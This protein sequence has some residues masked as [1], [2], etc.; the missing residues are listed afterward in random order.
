[1]KIRSLSLSMPRSP[2][3]VRSHHQPVRQG[4]RAGIDIRYYNRGQG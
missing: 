1:V 2:V 3:I 4:S